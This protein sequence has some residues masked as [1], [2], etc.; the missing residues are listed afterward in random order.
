V[1]RAP[2][3]TGGAWVFPGN[4]DAGLVV[5]ENLEDGVTIDELVTLYDGLTRD[6]VVAVLDF[7]ARSLEEPALAP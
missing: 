6:Q 2:E 7:A 4:A 5:F 1:E 3:K